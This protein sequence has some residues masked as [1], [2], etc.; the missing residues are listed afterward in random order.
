MLCYLKLI[1]YASERKHVLEYE[2][3]LNIVNTESFCLFKSYNVSTKLIPLILKHRCQFMVLAR[4]LDT[5][6]P[7]SVQVN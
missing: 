4:A 5:R 7:G 2:T 1:T 3:L 6:K